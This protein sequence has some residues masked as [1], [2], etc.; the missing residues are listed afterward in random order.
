MPIYGYRCSACGHQKDALQK[1]SDAPLTKCPSCEQETFCKE[2]SAPAFQLKGTG[3]YVTDF[4]DGNKG[5]S[6]AKPDS[7]GA[8]A[9]A[10]KGTSE[11]GNTGSD[12]S[13]SAASTDSAKSSDSAGSS[14]TPTPAPAPAPAPTSAGPA[15]SK[16]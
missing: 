1:L 6:D 14:S 7:D 12:K 16:D 3:W 13:A 10:D 4:R 11:S 2:V 9:P 8:A 5:K 15:A